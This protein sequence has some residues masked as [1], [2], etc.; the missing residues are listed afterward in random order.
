MSSRGSIRRPPSSWVLWSVLILLILGTPIYT[1]LFGLLPGPGPNW[2][3]IVNY[4]LADYVI[5]SF[6]LVMGTGLLALLWGVP[7][8]WFVS[9]FNF[10]G[11]RFW[12]WI[13]ILPL[14]IPTYIM[15]F[16]YAGIFDY[17]GPLQSLVRKTTG[18]NLASYL[19]IM[20]ITGVMVVMSLALFPYVYVVCRAAFLTRYRS[21]IEASQVLGASSGRSFF[22][23]VLPVARPALVAGVTLVIMEVLNDYGAVKYFGVPTFTTGIFRTWFSYEDPQGAIY[24]SSLL[25]LFV[26]AA[27]LFERFQRGK[28]RYHSQVPVERPLPRKRARGWRGIIVMSCCAIPAVLGFM[29]PV[30]QLIWWSLQSIGSVGFSKIGSMISN[31][32]LLACG[33]AVLCV[34]LALLL[35]FAT[36][37]RNYAWL[38]S[39]VR[40][41]TMGY[42]VPGAVIAVGVLIPLL[43]LDKLWISISSGGHHQTGLLLT[44]TVFGLLFAYSVRFLAV[45]FNP[46]ESGFQRIGKSLQEAAVTMGIKPW[47]ILQRINIPLLRGALVSAGLLVFI[48]VMKELPLTLIL[49]PFNFNTLATRAF[50]LATDELVAAAAIPSLI[51]I[52][53][54][55]IPIHLLNVLISKQKWT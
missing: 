26:F 41:S 6:L 33:A 49:R 15:A 40:L 34:L 42:A 11:R 35:I 14:T 28:A 22:K 45:A 7:S 5:N 27:I 46:I 2:S 37:V 53:T 32:F 13:L 4:L 8:A 55:V 18:L 20:N 1:V 3:H 17:A 51:I 47:R 10:P 44:G 31:S 23:V 52:I 21:M 16:T 50:E 29:L 36:R 9:T 54:G 38:H 48:D 30:A 24:L 43:F 25:L 12:E 39:A 19:D